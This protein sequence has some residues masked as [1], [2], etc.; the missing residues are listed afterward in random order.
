MSVLYP[1]CAASESPYMDI[2]HQRYITFGSGIDIGTLLMAL[3]KAFL[4]KLY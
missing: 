2:D 4:Q 1:C 3:A